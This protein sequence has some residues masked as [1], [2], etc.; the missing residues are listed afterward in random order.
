[1]LNIQLDGY[2]TIHKED[3]VWGSYNKEKGGIVEI[4]VS[5]LTDQELMKQ[6]ELGNLFLLVERTLK[7]QQWDDIDL[8]FE[9]GVL[10][11]LILEDF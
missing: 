1:M 8:D 11:D 6:L 5:G 9:V 10:E 7:K 4:D 2:I 3:A